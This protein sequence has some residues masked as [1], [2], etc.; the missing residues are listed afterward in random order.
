MTLITLERQVA[1]KLLPLRQPARY[2]GAFGGRGSGKSHDRAEALVEHCSINPGTRALCGRQVQKSL[3]ESAKQLV[4]DKIEQLRAPGFR[5]LDDRIITPGYGVI[6][7]QGLADHTVDSIKSFEGFD[8]FWIEEAHTITHNSLKIIRPTLRKPNSELWFTWNPRRKTDAVDDLLRGEHAGELDAIV[9]ESNW[10]DNPWFPDVLKAEREF[11]FNHNAAT[12]EHVWEGAYATVVQG[13]YYAQALAKAAQEGRICRLTT[14]PLLEVKAIWDLGVSDA[15]A[16][17][18]AQFS[19]REIRMLD[20]IEGEGQAL[21]YYVAEL[22]SKGW[23]DALCIL[24]HDGAHRDSVMAVKFEDHLK[25]AGFRTKTISNQ[26]A[27]AAR[28]RIEAA[29]RLFPRI[30]FDDERTS[31]GREAL[32]SYHEK[33]NDDREVGLGPEHDWAS[34]GADAFGLMAIAYEEP[35]AH[36]QRAS[37]SSTIESGAQNTAWMRG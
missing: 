32:G 6:V 31:A 18:I 13:A 37:R 29:R 19:G 24:P 21:A 30:W 23:G 35:K 7:F 17:W 11:D 36:I 22:R 2:K 1:R 5:P 16:I 14:D 4:T 25:Q 3:K 26:G 10:R 9:I 15:T 12:Y 8:I 33:R 27:G 34:H 28:L 20:Y